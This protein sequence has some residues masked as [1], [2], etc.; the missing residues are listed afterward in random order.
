MKQFIQ[1][2]D[3]SDIQGLIHKGLGYKQHPFMDKTLGAGKRAGGKLNKYLIKVKKLQKS[4][5]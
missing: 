1:V 3:V 2:G 4:Q 5:K